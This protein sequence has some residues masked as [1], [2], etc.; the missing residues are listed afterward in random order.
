MRG[1]QIKL[2]KS[3]QMKMP[4]VYEIIK[5]LHVLSK[6]DHNIENSVL[7]QS[8]AGLQYSVPL[9]TTVSLYQSCLFLCTNANCIPVAFEAIPVECDAGN[10][11]LSG[12]VHIHA[13]FIIIILGLEV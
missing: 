3:H 5:Q 12:T 6:H 7:A 10:L 8:L 13:P 1:L 4:A 2:L 11:L 9:K